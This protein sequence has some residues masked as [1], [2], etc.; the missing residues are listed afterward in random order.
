MIRFVLDADEAHPIPKTYLPLMKKVIR[1]CVAEAYPDHKFQVDLT[2]CG[3]EQIHELNKAYRGVDRPTDVLSFP[4]FE[5]DLPDVWVSLGS[6]VISADT[7][8]RQAEEYGHS[9]KRELCF[10]AAHSAL[11]LLGYDHETD[12][13]REVM[14]KKQ[15]D[16]LHS[17]GIDR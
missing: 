2:I 4:M 12:D 17:L 5:F 3:D 13:E 7:A 16:I 9:L 15:R 10:L 1:T 8:K 11:H 6:I 14:E